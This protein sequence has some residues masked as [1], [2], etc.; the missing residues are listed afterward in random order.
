M[1]EWHLM[2]SSYCG[3]NSSYS[4][5]D[6]VRLAISRDLHG[7]IVPTN[8]KIPLFYLKVVSISES[9]F[10]EG[11]YRIEIA[12]VALN[13]KSADMIFWRLIEGSRQTS[14][15]IIKITPVHVSNPTTFQE[16]L[17][18]KEK[19]S[20]KW[21]DYYSMDSAVPQT[22]FH[23]NSNTINYQFLKINEFIM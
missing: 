23:C 5:I 4:Q 20:K 18:W 22:K 3:N 12:V 15:P 11:R 8:T 10:K 14:D 1:G 13:K 17:E 9:V 21:A 2:S 16:C 6:N 19:E 7:W